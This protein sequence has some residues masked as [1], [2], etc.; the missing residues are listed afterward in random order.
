MASFSTLWFLKSRLYAKSG[1]L[2][3]NFILVT[4]FRSL[5]RGFTLN[6]DSLNRDFTVFS[7]FI[8]CS[9]SRFGSLREERKHRASCGSARRLQGAHSARHRVHHPPWDGQEP[10]S[11]LLRQQGRRPP[12]LGRVLGHRTRRGQDPPRE[13]RRHP[14]VG[15]GRFRQH[16]PRG[17]H[18]RPHQDLEEVAQEDQ[19]G[20]KEVRHVFRHR[21]HRSS[22]PRHG[23]RYL[24]TFLSA[25]YQCHTHRVR[26]KNWGS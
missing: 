26:R 5:H 19:R 20:P 11:G 8:G 3:W 15:S 16:V 25:N 18:V 6:R 22:R 13:G 14:Q 12:N 9:S 10:P 7:V 2:K 21:R 1:F 23:Q 24:L 17:S 4:R